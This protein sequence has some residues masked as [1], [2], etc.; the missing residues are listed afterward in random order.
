M[1]KTKWIGW[2]VIGWLTSCDGGGYSA[3]PPPPPLPSNVV[4]IDADDGLTFAPARVT[5]TVGMTVRW[6]NKGGTPHTVT[7]GA[8]SK[9]ADSPGLVFDSGL[10]PGAT[11]EHTFNTAGEQPYFCRYHEAMGMVGNITV[12]AT[13]SGSGGGYGGYGH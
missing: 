10:A 3:F 4:E 1:W 6:V 7:S 5:V 8:S 13:P 2:I 12:S 11:F 9:P